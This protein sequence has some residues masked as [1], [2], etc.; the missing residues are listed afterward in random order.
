MLLAYGLPATVVVPAFLHLAER[1][2]LL[3]AHNCPFDSKIMAAALWRHAES[4]DLPE[5]QA[6]ELVRAWQQKKQFCTMKATKPFV[7]AR[8]A[9]NRLK[10]PKLIEAYEHAFGRPLDRAHS[11]N[12]DTIAVL[13][14]YNWLQNNEEVTL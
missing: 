5:E 10:G 12:A 7:Q 3:V 14:L 8:S 9:N 13:E 6:H 1:A 11:A 2:D 4:I